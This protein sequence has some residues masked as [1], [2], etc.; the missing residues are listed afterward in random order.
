MV[1]W[2]IGKKNKNF[3]LIIDPEPYTTQEYIFHITNINEKKIELK[4]IATE[5]LLIKIPELKPVYNN[6]YN[7][8]DWMNTKR[9]Y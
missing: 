7:S 3:F 1:Y 2:Y 9:K 6:D 5:G 4:D 8:V